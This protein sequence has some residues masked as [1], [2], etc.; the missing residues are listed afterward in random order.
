MN[1]PFR[2]TRFLALTSCSKSAAAIQ[3]FTLWPTCCTAFASITFAS[4]LLCEITYSQRRRQVPGTKMNTYMEPS[5]FEPH[6]LAL[7]TLLTTH[8]DDFPRSNHPT[9]VLFKTR[10]CNPARSM[11]R[12]GLDQRVEQHPSTLDVAN[13][14]FGLDDDAIK[15]SEISLRVN[16]CR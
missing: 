12:I 7:W 15:R 5:S 8:L 1:E 13:L 9:R 4:S 6:I 14:C 10:G 11:L 16:R 3:I 2:N